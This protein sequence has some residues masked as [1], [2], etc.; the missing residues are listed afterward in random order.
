M[1]RKRRF[2]K[3]S[4]EV[5]ETWT[6][7][8]FLVKTDV[9]FSNEVNATWNAVTFLMKNY[10]TSWRKTVLE[11]KY[12]LHDSADSVES[13]E[14]GSMVQK[15][16]VSLNYYDYLVPEPLSDRPFGHHDHLYQTVRTFRTGH[17]SRSHD[18]RGG[19]C[20]VPTFHPLSTSG[21]RCA[22]P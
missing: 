13:E 18:G 12:L 1:R 6:F 2:S 3:L 7:V 20:G 14:S 11:V 19:Q 10:V 4:N 15:Q 17:E 21:C 9:M 16:W 8:N 5:N 22:P